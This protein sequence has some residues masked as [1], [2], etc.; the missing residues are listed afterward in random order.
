MTCF[1]SELLRLVGGWHTRIREVLDAPAWQCAVLF[2]VYLQEAMEG[3][4]NVISNQPSQQ[5]QLSTL[6]FT[7]KIPRLR[8]SCWRCFCP[9]RLRSVGL[10]TRVYFLPNH[11][12]LFLAVFWKISTIWN[13]ISPRTTPR[14]VTQALKTRKHSGSEYIISISQRAPFTCDGRISL[15]APEVDWIILGGYRS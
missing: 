8:C 14:A 2:Q 1:S 13:Q 10:L 4:R 15:S 9:A 12:I 5:F 11:F 3:L 7:C 6:L